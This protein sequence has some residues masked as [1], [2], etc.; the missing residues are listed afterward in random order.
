MK[1]DAE[2]IYQLHI[3]DIANENDKSLL[4]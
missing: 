3:C 4:I 1:N 2:I